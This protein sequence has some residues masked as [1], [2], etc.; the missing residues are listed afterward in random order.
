MRSISYITALLTLL[1]LISPFSTAG[2]DSS[3][4]QITG[5]WISEA[6]PSSKVLVAYMEISNS[7]ENAV[8]LIKVASD[9]FSSVEMHETVHEDGMA[10]MI[11]HDSVRIPADEVI[12][13]RRGGRHL[14]LFNPV[15]RLKAGDE[16]RMSLHTSDGNTITMNFPVRKAD[17]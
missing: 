9:M 7:S 17:Y 14:M 10:R 8:D 6:P 15:K 11:R 16:V 5:A 4:L 13:F 2:A 3:S 1:L 12:R